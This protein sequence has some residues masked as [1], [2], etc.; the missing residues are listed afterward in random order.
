MYLDR[1]LCSIFLFG[2]HVRVVDE[3]DALLSECRPVDPFPSTVQFR[4][5]D[6]LTLRGRRSGREVYYVRQ[7]PLFRQ[8]EQIVVCQRRFSCSGGA[9][10]QQ[11]SLVREKRLQEE[12]LSGSVCRLNDDVARLRIR[13]NR[14]LLLVDPI[15]PVHPGSRP[16]LFKAVVKNLPAFWK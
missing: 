3:T 7:I 12:D 6:V 1:R 4:H 13:W 11:R 10:E 5:D 16:P 15:G 14:C 2:G 8:R 9:A